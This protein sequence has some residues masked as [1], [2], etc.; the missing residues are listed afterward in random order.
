MTL[1]QGLSLA[2]NSPSELGWL[3]SKPQGPTSFVLSQSGI[4]SDVTLRLACLFLV[5]VWRLTSE[6]HFLQGK[7]FTDSFE[8]GNQKGLIEEEAFEQG[9]RKVRKVGKA[10]AV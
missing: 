7:H 5:R 8:K 1:R 4:T 6:A 3:A 10:G 2:Q 9:L